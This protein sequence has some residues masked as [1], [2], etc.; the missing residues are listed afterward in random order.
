MMKLSQLLFSLL[1]KQI[2]HIS[3][4][5]LLE[6]ASEREAIEREAIDSLPEHTTT[7]ETTSSHYTFAS[8]EQVYIVITF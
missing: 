2:K 1:A 3:S 5:T 8:Q 4:M 7:M 6:Q